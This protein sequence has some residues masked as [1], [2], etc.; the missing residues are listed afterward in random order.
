MGNDEK[1]INEPYGFIYITTNTVDGMRYLGR[2]KFGNDSLWRRYLGSGVVFKNALK[3]YGKEN[4]S[5]NIVCFCY[6]EEELNQAE[7]DLSV[8]FNVVD[9]D[10]WYNL[11]YGGG[12]TSGYHHLEEAKKKM[13]QNSI[14][15][16]ETRKKMSESAKARCTDEW[17]KR[18]SEIMKAKN[19]AGENNPNYGNH[20]PHKKNSFDITNKKK[21]ESKPPNNSWAGKNNPRHKKPLY[22]KN[23]PNYGNH[24]LA[25]KNNPRAR[26]IVQLTKDGEFL[27]KWDYIT[28]AADH[29]GVKPWNIIT[30]CSGPEK[31][32]SAY[33]YKWMYLED[34]EKQTQQND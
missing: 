6:S 17:R 8:F 21:N 32:K 1:I 18:A 20:K 12:A 30:C 34:Y 29:L 11:C 23:N 5:R 2:K 4:F 25:G 9:S 16:E 3:K 19:F 7:Y 22:G 28:Q 24:K 15:S 26:S 33:G 14:P 27:R 31:L 13:S 10:D